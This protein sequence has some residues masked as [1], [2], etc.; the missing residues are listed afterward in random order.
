M[1]RKSNQD[2]VG[3]LESNISKNRR[4]LGCRVKDT[5]QIKLVLRVGNAASKILAHFTEHYAK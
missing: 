2:E 3:R 5:L 4:E 1:K